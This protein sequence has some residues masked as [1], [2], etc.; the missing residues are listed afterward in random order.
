MTS[1]GTDAGFDISAYFD[2]EAYWVIWQVGRSPRGERRIRRI[3][4]QYGSEALADRDAERYRKSGVVTW[5]EKTSPPAPRDIPW[6]AI[7]ALRSPA[8]VTPSGGAI[9]LASAWAPPVPV[10]AGG[11]TRPPPT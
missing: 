5:V 2:T 9:A 8:I 1:D 4:Q 3:S 10:S 11:P 7:Q 6:E